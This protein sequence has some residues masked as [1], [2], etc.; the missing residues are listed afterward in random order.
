MTEHRAEI[1]ECDDCG[2][3]TTAEFADDVTHKV[4]THKVQYGPHLN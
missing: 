1:K 2:K 4:V 3:L